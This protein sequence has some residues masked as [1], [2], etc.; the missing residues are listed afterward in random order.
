MKVCTKPAD[1]CD[2]DERMGI[3]CRQY[4]IRLTSSPSASSLRPTQPGWPF[5]GALMQVLAAACG[6][7]IR[8]LASVSGVCNCAVIL[9][10]LREHTL[11]RLNLCLS[12]RNVC[13]TRAQSPALTR[14]FGSVRALICLAMSSTRRLLGRMA[15][16]QI[17]CRSG[18]SCRSTTAGAFLLCLISGSRSP[19]LS[20]I[21]LGAAI[22]VTPLPAPASE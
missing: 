2:C 10:N 17:T 7:P 5:A 3:G 11:A 15:I 20:S 9:T 6:V 21:K 12:M 19:R 16:C 4:V 18:T 22:A 13:S 8:G 14:S 1:A